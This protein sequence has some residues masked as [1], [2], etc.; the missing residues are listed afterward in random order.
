MLFL[1]REPYSNA[2]SEKAKEGW[3]RFLEHLN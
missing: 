3:D 2:I 1:L